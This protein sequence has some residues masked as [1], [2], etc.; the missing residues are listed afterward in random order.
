VIHVKQ[1][2]NA[3]LKDLPIKAV[4]GSANGQHCC[5]EFDLHTQFVVSR[6][7]NPASARSE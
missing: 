2:L 6:M 7:T 3:S 1:N 4:A 5:K